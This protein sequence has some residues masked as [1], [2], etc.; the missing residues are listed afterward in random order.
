MRHPKKQKCSH[1]SSNAP[2]CLSNDA[3]F[4]KHILFNTKGYRR[5]FV[6]LKDCERTRR[7]TQIANTIISGCVDRE[8]LFVDGGDYL[9]KNKELAVNIV[10]LLD[11]VKVIIQKKI[12]YNLDTVTNSNPSH[13]EE[14]DIPE[15]CYS[16][17]LQIL[18]EASSDILK[19]TAQQLLTESI[20]TGYARMR[21]TMLS[22]LKLESKALPS[23]YKMTKS[24][25]QVISMDIIQD[26]N[27]QLIDDDRTRERYSD[28][29]RS[30]SADED[31]GVEEEFI[32][33]KL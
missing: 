10:A 29:P 17:A 19:N 1:S 20:A 14:E 15:I 8:Q 2:I 33:E 13:C 6:Q 27:H 5:R 7:S 3:L 11:S 12:K 22:D 30:A 9:F 18:S 24:R 4:V 26:P 16:R 32:G 28:D 23:C 25:P 21:K 31:N